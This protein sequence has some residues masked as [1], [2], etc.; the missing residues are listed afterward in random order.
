VITRSAIV[1]CLLG[2]GLT[3]GCAQQ[4][5]QR[6]APAPSASKSEVGPPPLPPAPVFDDEV[7]VA[8]ILVR[9]KG[10]VGSHGVTRSREEARRIATDLAR[11]A[12]AGED[13]DALAV[14]HS[15]DA[16]SR[17]RGGWVEPVPRSDHPDNVFAL[18]AHALAVG[19]V[20]D[21]VESPEGFHV[22]RR[23]TL[24]Y[25]II[26]HILITH[27][28]CLQAGAQDRS[29][30]EARAL[31]EEVRRRALVGESFA[32]LAARFGEDATADHGGLLDP[33]P[34]G[35]MVAAFER[36]AFALQPGEISEVVETLYGFH[37]LLRER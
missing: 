15:E 37:V 32:E 29:P 9:Y 11:R 22:I 19:Q 3:L 17:E 12:Q 13:F 21:P 6:P 35:R 36:A 30:E 18:A 14:A 5:E 4:D 26:R 7:S 24:E 8:H 16:K 33:F 34:R 31:A 10:S 20:S 1:L 25:V 27:R 28:D 2:A 23:G